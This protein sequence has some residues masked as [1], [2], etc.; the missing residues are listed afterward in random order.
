MG[1]KLFSSLGCSAFFELS[2][3]VKVKVREWQL[4]QLSQASL[5]L[6][7]TKYLQAVSS[8]W[9]ER[10]GLEGKAPF[11]HPHP[12]APQTLGGPSSPFS[13]TARPRGQVTETFWVLFC[14]SV[15]L[16][17]LPHRTTGKIK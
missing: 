3:K 4:L 7:G 16:Q 2:V 13:P 8:L 9:Y 1:L 14:S 10:S 6:K 5:R 15:K 12:L 17:S 11:P